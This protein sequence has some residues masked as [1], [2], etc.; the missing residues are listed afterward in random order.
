MNTLIRVLERFPKT[1]GAMTQWLI[2]FEMVGIPNQELVGLIADCCGT[3]GIKS[4]GNKFVRARLVSICQRK[5]W[6]EVEKGTH[7]RWVEIE[8]SLGKL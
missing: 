4:G 8:Q 1:N 7:Y 2:S 5:I 6:D 3:I